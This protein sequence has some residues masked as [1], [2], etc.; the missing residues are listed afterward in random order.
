M[1]LARSS[2]LAKLTADPRSCS[3]HLFGR[4]PS[5]VEVVP[6]EP[7]QSVLELMRDTVWTASG[8]ADQTVDEQLAEYGAIGLLEAAGLPGIMQ[9]LFTTF[10]DRGMANLPD[11][12]SIRDAVARWLIGSERRRVRT[13]VK[14]TCVAFSR[15]TEVAV[16]PISA[17]TGMPDPLRLDEF[18][19]SRGGIGTVSPATVC[20]WV[21]IRVSSSQWPG[22]IV[23]DCDRQV[24][25]PSRHACIEAITLTPST[26][27]PGTA[28]FPPWYDVG[29]AGNNPT[30][31]AGLVWDVYLFL[32]ICPELN[33][34]SP[35]PIVSEHVTLSDAEGQTTY[36]FTRPRAARSL[37]I[38]AQTAAQT[39]TMTA[40]R[41][42][43]LATI[44]VPAGQVG[45]FDT[46][47]DFT[48]I[49][50]PTAAASITHTIAWGVQP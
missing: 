27:F 14:S 11:A 30:E 45:V 12:G 20:P 36:T 43:D 38:N 17:A 47:P 29:S 4:A 18:D 42:V 15:E 40:G 49:R 22:P 25:V 9:R 41:S 31:L 33:F 50:T 37:F 26:V 46:L 3:V 2:N 13:L 28:A 34:P 39:W 6:A 7:N 5:S 8:P 23:M 21:K 24:V 48:H 1:F 32:K 16:A 35:I 44:Q 19:V 10:R